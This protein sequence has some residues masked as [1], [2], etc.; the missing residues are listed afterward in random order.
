MPRIGAYRKELIMMN[1]FE[2]RE[3]YEDEVKKTYGN[4]FDDE[5]EE[6]Q[7]RSLILKLEDMSSSI[8]Q[9]LLILDSILNK[10]NINAY[11]EEIQIH[12]ISY[13]F[14]TIQEE[15]ILSE[16]AKHNYSYR[17]LQDICEHK[18]DLDMQFERIEDD[19]K[20]LGER[21]NNERY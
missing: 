17:S 11:L 15:K 20:K 7:R 2:Y 1:N 18:V 3:G 6:I 12:L 10:Y 14:T 16:F 19:L 21:D 8:K 4:M 9:E 13:S 5:Y